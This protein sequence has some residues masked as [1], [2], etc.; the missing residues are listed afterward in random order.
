MRG[1]LGGVGGGEGVGGFEAWR[2][3][4]FDDGFVDDAGVVVETSCEGEVERNLKGE[5]MSMMARV[6]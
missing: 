5:G 4:G 2:S 3:G 1:G 6:W